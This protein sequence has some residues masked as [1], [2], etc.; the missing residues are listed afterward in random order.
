VRVTD[1][2]PGIEPRLAEDAFRLYRLLQPKGRYPGIGM[3]LPLARRRI[4]VQGGRLWIE[5]AE[6]RGTTVVLR[7]AAVRD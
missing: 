6:G 1:D 2:G 3:G 4:E 7:L 5:A